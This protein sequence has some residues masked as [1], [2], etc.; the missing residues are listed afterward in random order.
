MDTKTK[1]CSEC[2]VEKIITQDFPKNGRIYRAICKTCHCRK[3]KQRYEG[4]NKEDCLK[5]RRELYQ[6]NKD[7]ILEKNKNYR[8]LHKEEISKSKREYYTKMRDEILQKTKNKEY[9]DKRNKRLRDRRQ[10]DKQFAMVCSYRTRLAEVLQKQKR[11]TYISYLNC[12]REQF[13]DWIYFQFDGEFEWE[14]Y[15]TKWVIDHVIPIEFFDL[16][17]KLE[18]YFCFSWFNL[19]PLCK[20]ENLQ[21]SN[22]LLLEVVEQHQQKI[23]DFLEI[24]NWYQAD[25][26]IHQWLREKLR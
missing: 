5:K 4:K 20:Q 9:K 2:H 11:N 25:V 6:C 8:S 23:Y 3:Q 10:N 16:N 1:T 14:G 13:L 12:K 17:N 18:R 26:E 15:S 21:K 19:R 22:K 24:K 7:V